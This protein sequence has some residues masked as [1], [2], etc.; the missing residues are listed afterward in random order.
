MR[1]LKYI[2]IMMFLTCS[3]FSAT[4]NL[5]KQKSNESSI[6]DIGFNAPKGEYNPNIPKEWISEDPLTTEIQRLLDPRSRILSEKIDCE[7]DYLGREN[8]PVQ[9]ESC[10]GG[11]QT[12]DGT[13]Q[14]VDKTSYTNKIK[15][16]TS[17][18]EAQNP[19]SLKG[20]YKLSPTGGKV[21]GSRFNI[22]YEYNRSGGALPDPNALFDAGYQLNGKFAAKMF[23]FGSGCG[24][25]TVLPVPDQIITVV[26]GGSNVQKRGFTKNCIQTISSGNGDYAVVLAI[27]DTKPTSL[28]YHC[29][30]YCLF[31]NPN[32]PGFG[33]WKWG[34]P[35]NYV[36]NDGI[37]SEVGTCRKDYSYYK[38]SCPNDRNTY[39]LP[40][41]GP[42]VDSGNDCDGLCGPSG[43]VCNSPTPPTNNCIRDTYTCPSN[44]EQLCN[45]TT[46]DTDSIDNIF[47]SFVYKNGA[48]ET[49]SKTAEKA[50]ECPGGHTWD[51][52]K[53]LCVIDI[54]YTCKGTGFTYNKDTGLCLKDLT[55]DGISMPDGSCLIEPIRECEDGFEFDESEG[56]CTKLPSCG[57]DRYDLASRYCEATPLCSKPGFTFDYNIRKCTKALVHTPLRCID[58]SLPNGNGVCTETKNVSSNV[59]N[60]SSCAKH[61]MTMKFNH[62]GNGSFDAI[63]INYDAT[64][65]PGAGCSYQE[66][67][68][69]RL[70]SNFN[71]APYTAAG[72]SN[73]DVE[74]VTYAYSS[75]GSGC[76]AV[77][78]TTSTT[79]DKEVTAFCPDVNSQTVSTQVRLNGAMKISYTT[80][81]P[82]GYLLNLETSTCYIEEVGSE[83]DFVKNL[84]I[85]E[86]VCA[87][88]F[89]NAEEGICSYEPTCDNASVYDT[90][91]RKCILAP[92]ESCPA[93]E[94]PTC[95]TGFF[96]N[97]VNQKCEQSAACEFGQYNHINGKCEEAVICEDGWEYNYD[98]GSCAISLDYTVMSCQSFETHEDRSATDKCLIQKTE[99]ICPA[100]YSPALNAL[101][102]ERTITCPAGYTPDNANNLCVKTN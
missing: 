61:F 36:D 53:N 69:G 25:M 11:D 72:A 38:Y 17:R 44:P 95:P 24:G 70:N 83:A 96:Y 20:Q 14:R 54:E 65:T 37:I 12:D 42:V 34:C 16:S 101:Y 74:S 64:W 90:D 63:G 97:Q 73:I 84:F 26:A 60:S 18:A 5:L 82:V 100:N 79:R 77:S 58:G 85:A 92:Y 7:I 50:K 67:N 6:I 93:I 32:D 41:L 2:F 45:I 81:C 94:N 87:Q 86:P 75:N 66:K 10:V 76:N 27:W 19:N 88:G 78:G 3:A 35:T 59:L 13:S 80:E 48:A 52:D 46:E 47:E 55:C 28:R 29:D 30:D 8:C 99:D 22:E 15:I 39:D 9:M 1:V 33:F 51:K 89:Y 102:C 49:F 4:N 91:L 68:F 57:N 71:L 31:G 62:V 40:W 21:D 98:I 43:C 23:H 56:E